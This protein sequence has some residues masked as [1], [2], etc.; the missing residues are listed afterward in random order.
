M[1]FSVFTGLRAVDNHFSFPYVNL[2]YNILP[3]IF[4]HFIQ[5]GRILA[6]AAETCPTEIFWQSGEFSK[7]KERIMGRTLQVRSFVI[8][9][10]PSVQNHQIF[11]KKWIKNNFCT[12]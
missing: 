5:K 1:E 9:K 3:E 10:I 2:F 6:D 8:A 7:N 4:G 12:G 11:I